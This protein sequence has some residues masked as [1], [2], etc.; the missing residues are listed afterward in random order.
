MEKRATNKEYAATEQFRQKCSKLKVKPTARQ[1]SKYR[2]Q[3]GIVYN[4]TR[5]GG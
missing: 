1:A 2:N 3:K 4:S 5:K